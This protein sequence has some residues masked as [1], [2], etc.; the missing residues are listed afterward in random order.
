MRYLV[1]VGLLLLE[2]AAGA[3]Q[4]SPVPMVNGTGAISGVVIDSATKQPIAVAP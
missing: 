1:L 2:V 3:Q 4:P